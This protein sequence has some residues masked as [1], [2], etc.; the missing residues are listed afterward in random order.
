[1]KKGLSFSALLLSVLV[2]L[3]VSFSFMLWTAAFSCSASAPG[4]SGKVSYP[5]TLAD[6]LG[7][8]VTLPKAP[9]R[10]VSVA[11]SVTEMLF[12]LGL[13]DRVVGVT[14]WCTYP[15]AARALPKVGDMTLSE[16]KIAALRPDLIVGDVFLEGPF[17]QRLDKL[18][19]P[20]VAVGPQRVAD[21]PRALELLARACGVPE[22]GRREATRYRDRLAQ[23]T[24]EGKRNV[25]PSGERARVFVL[26]DPQQLYTAGPGT[27]LDELIRL[28]GGRNVAG[29]AKTPWPLLSE[30]ALLLSDPEV[31]VL[32]CPPPAPVLQKPQWQGITALRTGQV[33]PVDPDI[34]SRPGPRL[35]DGLEFLIKRLRERR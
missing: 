7:R 14:R 8:R 31:I 34:V 16:E 28:A 10:I 26:L 13:G 30:E 25:R 11:P 6:D 3:A 17:L 5:L 21:V 1:M 9:Q 35:L 24:R 23:L 15:A 19:W 12:A 2:L 4:D 29:E 32:A 18:G 27:F 20:V 33:Y 22:A